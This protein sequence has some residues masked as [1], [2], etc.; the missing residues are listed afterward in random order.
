MRKIIIV[1]ALSLTTLAFMAVVGAGF[2][3]FS[4]GPQRSVQAL[5]RESLGTSGCTDSEEIVRVSVRPQG[6][7]VEPL[8]LEM[9]ANYFGLSNNWAGGPQDRVRI[10]A[11]FPSLRARP[12][13]TFWNTCRDDA[14]R[15][16]PDTRLSD[17]QAD[18]LRIEIGAGIYPFG[19]PREE[20][21][22]M[23]SDVD[24]LKYLQRACVTQRTPIPKD[25][26]RDGMM[27]FPV[28][29]APGQALSYQ[30]LG[31]VE[32]PSATCWGHL[33]FRD[34]SVMFTFKRSELRRWRELNA[35][36]LD[37]LTRHTPQSAPRPPAG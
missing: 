18:E 4:S 1:L 27:Y 23:E 6:D 17:W 19:G 13:G 33:L 28:E 29:P 34:H 8:T 3:V 20:Y 35:G 11:E 9:P 2:F 31:T 5:S 37:L 21:A 7:A 12:S 26:C 10:N 36:V 14:A 25:G 22:E 32:N 24:G 15:K 30:C 16:K